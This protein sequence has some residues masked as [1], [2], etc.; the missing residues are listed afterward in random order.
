MT[1]R[2]AGGVQGQGLPLAERPRAGPSL[3]RLRRHTQQRL[4]RTTGGARTAAA[5]RCQGGQDPRVH[6]GSQ[7]APSVP[8]ETETMLGRPG[9]PLPVPLS[10]RAAAAASGSD[11]RCHAHVCYTRPRDPGTRGPRPARDLR[12][13]PP[14]LRP[15]PRQRSL[16]VRGA[17]AEWS[18]AAQ[19]AEPRPPQQWRPGAGLPPLPPRPLSVSGSGSGSRSRSTE[20]QP[21][22]GC[23]RTRG[24]RR[25]ICPA[26]APPPRP[27][28]RPVF[29]GPPP[30]QWRG[31]CA[32]GR[33]REEQREVGRGCRG[34][35]AGPAGRRDRGAAG[36]AAKSRPI[37]EAE[38]H[39]HSEFA[40]Q[41]VLI[42]NPELR[43]VGLASQ[44]R[45]R[46]SRSES[47]SPV[48]SFVF[49]SV[50]TLAATGRDVPQE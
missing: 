37:P 42:P 1:A 30:D 29:Q 7:Q 27:R 41:A 2:T 14:H 47:R 22:R 8:P 13:T 23:G 3:S 40:Q 35:A 16:L 36:S 50:R 48:P 9:S 33:G 12:L 26:R 17:R 44:T 15:P 34:G 21:A 20:Q 18:G 31:S 10:L 11:P 24:Q 32:E 19:P 46:G 43:F 38:L 5:P 4:G 49:C 28:R 45:G 25:R 6:T 39:V